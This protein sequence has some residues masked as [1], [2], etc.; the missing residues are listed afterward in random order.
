MNF[1]FSENQVIFWP[2]ACKKYWCDCGGP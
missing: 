2:K 1:N